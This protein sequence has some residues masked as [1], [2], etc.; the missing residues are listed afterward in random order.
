MKK[1]IYLLLAIF[2]G[3]LPILYT[4]R[5]AQA[6]ANDIQIYNNGLVSPWTDV[7]WMSSRNLSATTNDG[8]TAIAV[9]AK[10]WGGLS[11]LNGSWQ[12]FNAIT[13][14]SGA[15]LNFSIYSPSATWPLYIQLENGQSDFPNVSYGAIAAGGWKTISVPFKQLDPDGLP[16][17]RLDI[18][19]GQAAQFYIK[20]I[21]LN[22]AGSLTPPPAPTVNVE[23]TSPTNNQTV[24]GSITIKATAEQAPDNGR[25]NFYLDNSRLGPPLS[26][27]FNFTWDT[28]KVKN[29]QHS[30]GAVLEYTAGDQNKVIL[31]TPITVTVNNSSTGGGPSGGG[32]ASSTAHWISAYYAGWSQ[33]WNPDQ[34]LLPADKIDYKAV[35]DIIHFA[36]FP[37]PDGTLNYTDNSITPQNSQLATTAAHAAGKKILITVGGAGSA[38]NF[39]A[40]TDSQNQATF[41]NNIVAF[42]KNRHYDGVDIDWETLEQS[43]APQY[44]SFIKNLRA[45]LTSQISSTTLLTAATAWQPAL[46]ASLANDFDQINIMTYDLSGA[47]PGW[48]TWHNSP[49]YNGG[50]TFPSTGGPLPSADT[51][52]QRFE[53]AGV[54]KQKLGIGIDFYGDIWSGGLINTLLGGL[55]G[56]DLSWISP[57]TVQTNIPYYQLA[58]TYNF[59]P[60][61]ESSPYYHWDSTADAPYLSVPGGLLGGSQFV[62]FDNAESIAAKLGYVKNQD[63]GGVILWE[64]GGDH[65]TN[66]PAGSADPLL[67]AVKT[68][69]A[70]LKY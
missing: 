8:Q 23:I 17:Y 54:P 19:A 25:I 1:K 63:I 50:Q 49:L 45:A 43:D 9:D 6:S 46:F 55:L 5:P 47:W 53:A 68:A 32:S 27:P 56:P 70:D 22:A 37:N 26:A 41:V 10:A 18:I 29:G 28:T 42:V 44:A 35:T 40:A 2:L 34:G 30:L 61:D 7:S 39:R 36:L 13:P 16:F 57:P 69:A 12:S 62:S 65:I 64:L 38:D 31:A 67:E 24:A 20:D 66:A 51:E 21:Y 59:Q 60:R 48:V 52:V 14:A 11:L 4:N 3:I 15:S 58:Q 33:G